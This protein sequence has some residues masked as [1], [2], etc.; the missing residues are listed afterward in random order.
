[1]EPKELNDPGSD[2]RWFSLE[3]DSLL[4]LQNPMLES[5]EEQRS[6]CLDRSYNGELSTSCARASASY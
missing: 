5:T 6:F 4:E 3:P 1:M 2:L